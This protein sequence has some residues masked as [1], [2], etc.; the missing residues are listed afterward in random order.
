MDGLVAEH[1]TVRF[2][3]VVALDDVSIDLQPGRLSGL[4][5]PNGAGKTT[6]FNV[7]T[8]LIRPRTGTVTIDGRSIT[9]VRPHRRASL[10][11]ARTFQRLELFGSLSVRDNVLVAAELHR[12]RF[13]GRAALAQHVDRVLGELGLDGEAGRQADS[14]PTGTA[15]ML[16]VARAMATR[17]RYLLLDEPSAGLDTAETRRF[18]EVLVS[19][20]GSDD[21]VGILL[22]EHDI[23]LVMRICS[24][25]VV[26]NFGQMVLRGTPD[27]VQRSEEVAVAYLGSAAAVVDGAS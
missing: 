10:G 5:G 1:V 17:P 26:L 13:D 18:G 14:L 15:R 22:V 4:I 20:T 25:V 6:L 12:N 9:A 19:M 27:E 23:G 21:G 7:L 16:E 2:G 8:G 11:I 24:D 3:G